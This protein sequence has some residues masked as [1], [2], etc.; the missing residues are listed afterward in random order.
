MTRCRMAAFAR[1][2]AG[3]AA[4]GETIMARPADPKPKRKKGYW[5]VRIRGRDIHLGKDQRKAFAKFHRLM[6]DTLSRDNSPGRPTTIAG[7]A[8]VWC[9]IH[10]SPEHIIWLRQFIRFAGP[11]HLDE[12]TPDLLHGY[13]D[14]LL[15]A[16]YRSRGK[17]GKPIGKPKH[18]KPK[19]I[20]HYF[21]DAKAV[22]R[23]AAN[24][25]WCEMP[26]VPKPAK[27]HFVDRS[28]KSD[29]WDN[30]DAMPERA[31]RLLKFI[32]ATGCRPSEA[33]K[34]EWSQVHR[35][36][37][38]CVLPDHK[39]ADK[40]GEPRRIALTDEA[41]AVLRDTPRTDH[42]NVFLSRFGRPYTVQG[43]RSIALAHLGVNPYD[44]RHTFAQCA[45]DSGEAPATVTKL[46]GHK[47]SGMVWTYAQIRERQLIDTARNLKL[48][49]RA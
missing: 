9:R 3:G 48:R 13:H 40:T 2:E 10:K 16:T 36:H 11:T 6:A 19:T 15:K 47:T 4:F 33:I 49:K 39:T 26:D 23:L 41:L 5:S 43:L 18:Y 29:L 32:A 42:P 27:S 20:C 35:A 25:K 37:R 44:L 30:L 7:A 24:R 8:E 45:I 38:V 46:L 12:V 1:R 31:G 34:L 21:D 14:R 22:L 28:A 17:D